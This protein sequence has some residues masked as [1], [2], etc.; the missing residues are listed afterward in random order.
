MNKKK[1][2]KMMAEQGRDM[3]SDAAIAQLKSGRLL[4]GKHRLSAVAEAGTPV[5]MLVL[6]DSSEEG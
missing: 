6:R 5:Y 4:N 2:I 1:E 3:R